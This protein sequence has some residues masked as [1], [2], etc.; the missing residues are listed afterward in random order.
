MPIFMDRR[1]ISDLKV[2]IAIAQLHLN[3]LK[4][5]DKFNCKVLNHWFDE[6]REIAFSLISAPNKESLVGL[7]HQTKT[8]L[9]LNITELDSSSVDVFLNQLELD[10]ILPNNKHPLIKTP[11]SQTVMVIGVLLSLTKTNDILRVGECLKEFKKTTLD[12]IDQF[13]GIVVKQTSDY[14]IVSFNSATKGLKCAFKVQKRFDAYQKKNEMQRMSLKIGFNAV[15]PAIENEEHIESLINLTRRLAFI[16]QQKIIITTEIET[17]YKNENWN[18]FKDKNRIKC[19]SP[20]DIR[21]LSTLMEYTEKNWN[22]PNLHVED[23]EKHLGFSKSQIYRKMI[24]IVGK[25]PNA[26]IK[27][28]RLLRAINFFR[29]KQ[30]NIS[31]GAFDCG[32]SSPSYFTKCFQKEFGIKPSDYIEITKTF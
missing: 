8:D 10:E 9:P 24:A 5:Q 32:F 22:N 2:A 29:Q 17:L 16:S 31:E 12:I 6:K 20:D 30:G 4:L 7:H 28:Y 19:L 23:F 11:V 27:Q 15:T 1:K 3:Y 26:F 21:F 13:E 25:S 14:F 18:N